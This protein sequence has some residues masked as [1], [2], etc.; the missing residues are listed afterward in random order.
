MKIKNNRFLGVLPSCLIEMA[1]YVHSPTFCYSRVYDYESL[2]F[3]GPFRDGEV[4][5]KCIKL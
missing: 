1:S 3:D 5:D 4:V 2:T